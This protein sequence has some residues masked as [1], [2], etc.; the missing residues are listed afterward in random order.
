MLARIH[1]RIVARLEAAIEILYYVAMI[2]GA[3]IVWAFLTGHLPL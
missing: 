3:V 2:P 1:A